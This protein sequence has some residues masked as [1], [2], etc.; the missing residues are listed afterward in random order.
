MIKVTAAD[1]DRF[2]AE[3]DGQPIVML[4]LLRF[5]A[6]GGRQ[7]YLEYLAMAGPIVARYGAEILFAGD[8][9]A[10]LC[11]E[12]GQSWDAVALVRYPKRTA[13]VDMI[14]DPSYAVADPIRMSALEEAVLQPIEAM[15]L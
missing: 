14:A 13:F 7:R 1:I 5:K 6:D 3:D 8:G 11:A 9:L 2:F 4:N 15:K 10:A 12:P